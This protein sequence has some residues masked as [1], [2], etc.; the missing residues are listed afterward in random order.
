MKATHLFLV[1]AALAAGA[2]I[3][4]L[5]RGGL[6][7]PVVTVSIVGLPEGTTELD[8]K[9]TPLQTS[10][11]YL[12]RLRSAHR[13][14]V[15][16]AAAIE[17]PVPAGMDIRLLGETELR[18]RGS[19]EVR[20]L[21]TCPD[22]LGP[23]QGRITLSSPDLPGWSHTWRFAGE[24]SRK[25][26]EGGVLYLEPRAA[27]LGPVGPGET[28]PFSFLLRSLGTK[29]VTIL[30]W[31]VEDPATMH[32]QG[33]R[34]GQI[35]VPGGEAAITGSVVA[36]RG[37]GRF[38]R[39]VQ[40]VSD[41][42]TGARREFFVEGTVLLPYSATPEALRWPIAVRA[43]HTECTILLRAREGG[44]PFLVQSV[45]GVD[46]YFDT[47]DTGRADPA[48]EQK[49]RLRLRADAPLGPARF[50]VRFRLAPS[51]TELEWPVE[52]NV[53]SRIVADPDRIAFGRGPARAAQPVEIAIQNLEQSDF[54]VKEVR[55][56]SFVAVTWERMLG[57]RWTLKVSLKPDTL[58][59]I[60]QD[61]IEVYTNDPETP[62][63]LIQVFAEVTP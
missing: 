62:N 3:W 47:V 28:R 41:A 12:L 55:A 6:G 23:F 19:G 35:V 16:I 58:P 50:R 48:A 44:E 51:G 61:R 40:I 8:M 32:L 33:A 14:S 7:G 34:N 4:I 10:R 20:M 21:V 26:Q 49:V 39:T 52:M 45:S 46:P 5:A 25:P 53:V 29:E 54:E 13:E 38:R 22:V 2:A 43:Q 36:P 60:H 9:D 30:D 15:R 1:V 18:P 31:K 24:I 57:S 11:Q 56:P 42:K 27:D 37:G 63:L 59:G 17:A